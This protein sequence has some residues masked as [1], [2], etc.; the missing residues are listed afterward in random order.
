MKKETNRLEN[1]IK[2]LNGK[3][4]TDAIK[5]FV[6]QRDFVTAFSS[7]RIKCTQ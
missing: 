1:N 4:C 2:F 6:L 3:I 5:F 7:D